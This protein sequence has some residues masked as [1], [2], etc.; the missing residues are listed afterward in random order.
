MEKDPTLGGTCLNVGCIPSKALLHNSH[1]FHMAKH[2]DMANRGIE[3]ELKQCVTN[4]TCT[5]VS[6]YLESADQMRK[7]GDHGHAK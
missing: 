1:L 5:Q 6:S 4:V 3:C 7:V 2:N